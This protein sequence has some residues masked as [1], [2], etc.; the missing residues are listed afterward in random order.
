MSNVEQVAREARIDVGAIAAAVFARLPRIILL[1]LLALAA[2]YVVLLFTPRLYESTAS[3][4]VEPRANI[5]TRATNEPAATL[6]GNEA[7]VVSSQIELLKSRDTLLGVVEATDLRSVPEFAGSEGGLSIGAVVNRLLGR[8]AQSTAGDETILTNLLG[9][10]TVVQQRDSRV[11]NISVRSR[12]PEL[13]ARLANAIARAHV[14][15][16]AELSLTDTANAS[17]WL[18]EEIDRLRVSVSEAEKAVAEFRVDNDLFSGANN[19][20]LLDQQL[21]TIAN[22]ITTAQERKNQALSRAAIIRGLVEQGQAIDGVPD[23]QQSVVI[24]QLTQER[25]RLQGE[26][27]QLS[28]TL[29]PNHPNVQAVAAQISELD[30]QLREEAR[31]IAAALES[32]AEI[33]ANTEQSLRAELDSLKGSASTATRDN[34]TLQGLIREADAQRDL[35][36]SYLRR[37]SEAVSRTDTNSALPD[38]RVVSE[39]APSVTPASPQSTLVL[40]AVGLVTL[41]SQVGIVVLSELV[42]GRAVAAPR[43]VVGPDEAERVEP[44]EL[45]AY[46]DKDAT[47]DPEPAH[48]VHEPEADAFPEAPIAPAE[49]EDVEADDR[50]VEDDALQAGVLDEDLDA[51]LTGEAEP[52]YASQV[53]ADGDDLESGD[54]QGESASVSP[55]EPGSADLPDHA[56]LSSDLALGRCR[57]VVLAGHRDAMDSEMLADV[58]AEESLQRGLSVAIVDAASGRTGGDF[59]IADLSTGA[60]SF[61]DVVQKSTDGNFAEVPW[62]QGSF[63]DRRSPRPATLVEALS[64]IYEV[65][66]VATGKLGMASTLPAFADIADRIVLVSQHHGDAEDIEALRQELAA[67]GYGDAELVRTP[68]GVA[69]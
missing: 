6:T 34:V 19:T 25:A 35:L 37:Y 50:M 2:A 44:I 3:I 45:P 28:A 22:Q 62:G 15:R 8:S 42:S 38:V 66:I 58:L 69:A 46:V 14:A 40:I 26:R 20:S 43:A 47:P 23:V 13:A 67:A 48:L 61:G 33:E 7:G 11:I 31:R 59:G 18:R 49:V 57:V 4:L 51:E 63:F 60:A 56:R 12:D 55:A 1:T 27:A 41:V 32:E 65:V 5:Y 64:D 9:R 21:S 36:E 29:L 17:D 54:I 16:R 52:V 68:V 10:M 53:T 24:Q 39:A 30:A